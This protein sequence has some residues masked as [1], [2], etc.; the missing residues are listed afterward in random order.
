M[1]PAPI[2]GI[3]GTPWTEAEI[4]AVVDSYFR[5][6]AAEKAGVAYSKADNWRRLK[7]RSS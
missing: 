5:M 3:A 2:E 4:S 6:L 1:D 7:T